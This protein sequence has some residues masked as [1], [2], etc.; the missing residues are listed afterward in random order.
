MHRQVY[1][2]GLDGGDLRRVTDDDLEHDLAASPS[3][4]YAVD[5]A[6]DLATPSVSVL[7]GLDTGEVLPLERADPTAL[8][9]TGWTPPER[10]R[11]LAADGTTPVYGVL[12]RSASGRRPPLVAG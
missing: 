7:R 5:V 6:S 8:L 3:G 11:A 4:R 2:V 9:A 12:H 1:R 10:F